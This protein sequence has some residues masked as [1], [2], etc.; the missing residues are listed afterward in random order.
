MAFRF[1]F[2]YLP[3]GDYRKQT[4]EAHDEQEPDHPADGE[5]LDIRG[6]AP[7]AG[8]RRYARA[9]SQHVRCSPA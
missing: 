3:E 9:H 2:Y 8:L 1:D 5:V 7:S 6:R 4:D